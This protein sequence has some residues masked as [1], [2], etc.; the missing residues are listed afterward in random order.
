MPAVGDRF[1]EMISAD[2]TD[3][4]G[5]KPADRTGEAGGEFGF[6]NGR[7]GVK[8]FATAGEVDAGEAHWPGLA[9][10]PPYPPPQGGRVFRS[11][12]PLRGRVRVGGGRGPV[13]TP[14]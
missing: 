3:R 11:P 1:G 10:S 4:G 9:H 14:G 6:A 8:S 2:V 12:P 7:G 13:G 5:I